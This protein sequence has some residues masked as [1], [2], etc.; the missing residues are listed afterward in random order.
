MADRKLTN[1]FDGA[2]IESF[3]KV[4]DGADDELIALK[5]EHM[6]AC[7]GPRGKIRGAMT[8]AKENGLNMSAFR[9]LVAKHRGER[10]IDQ[11]LSELEADDHADYQQM[12]VAL[13]EFGDT[14]LGQAALD[15]LKPHEETLTNLAAG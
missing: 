7:K 13:G 15:K 2:Q 14:P 10:K 9:A 11:Q 8:Q 6:R 4:I 3:L 12:L 1:G 5:T